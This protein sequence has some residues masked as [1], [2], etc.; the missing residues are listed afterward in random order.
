MASAAWILVPLLVGSAEAKGPKKAA[1]VE[2]PP[3]PTEGWVTEPG[4]TGACWVPPDFE[5][6]GIGDRRIARN[7][8]LEAMKEQ[9]SGARAD[10]V[11]FASVT[12]SN[13]ETVLLG[14]PD[15]I[16]AVA[17]DN[18]AQCRSAMKGGGTSGWETWLA[19]L[20]RK[21]TEGECRK[22][23]D[24]TMFWY[25]DIGTGWQGGADVC[26]GD[27]VRIWSTAKDYYK[28]DDGGPWINAEGDPSKPATG[29]GYLCTV[30]GCRAG[31]V[32]LRFRG[33]SGAEVI[34]P[35]GLELKFTAPEHG[36]IE[37]AVNDLTFVNNV[38]K[39]ERGMQ[40]RTAVTYEPVE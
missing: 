16:E 39:V 29:D 34:K 35:V 21:L 32:V 28:V 31:Q 40:H 19:S 12:L 17:R 14:Y 8:T 18:L 10:G 13:L 4:A 11:A 38:F 23:L 27:E 26:Q 6:M 1:V 25:M 37:F 33:Q 20:P 9:W 5:A 3:A 22:P 7:T 24:V 36:V 2:A 30:E 15:K